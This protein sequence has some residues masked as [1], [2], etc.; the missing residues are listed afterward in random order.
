M[1]KIISIIIPVY[2]VEKYL[3]RCI[4][5]VIHQSYEKLQ[6]IL[7]D[8]GSTD[9]SGFIC[10]NYARID[11][12]IEVIHKSNGGLSDARNVGL[13]ISI[14][15]YIM[16][17]DS[18]DWIRDDCIEILVT[19]LRYGKT[20]IS[21]CAYLKTAVWD[22]NNTIKKIN[23]A[24]YITIWNIDDAYKH[25]F[26]QQKI[27]NSVWAKMYERSLFNEIRFP[28][29]RLHEDH[30][31]TYKLFHAAQGVTYIEQEA[32]FY[33]DR[34]GSIQ[35]ESFSLRKLD[36]LEAAE[37]CADF[38]MTNYPHLSEEVH[39]RLVSSCFHILFSIDVKKR[40]GQQIKLLHKIIKEYRIEMILGKNVSKKVRFGCLFTYFGFNFTEWIYR[41]LGV[42][43]K[44]NI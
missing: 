39:C 16:F 4:E 36:E 15:D 24:D 25:L 32:Y 43:G 34:Q 5:S 12:R 14:G 41:N 26:L 27:G 42:R 29:S 23:V 6:I 10:D 17:V 44:I 3:E 22:D 9:Q 30:F 19:A 2:N 40:W 7:V 38:I 11:S 37:E 13:D 31:I 35:N 21:A 18:D 20:K 1:D 28:M 33:F 8:D